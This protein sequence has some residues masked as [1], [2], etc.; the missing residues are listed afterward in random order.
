MQQCFTASRIGVRC[1]F[2]DTT[3]CYFDLFFFHLGL[4][5]V[6][7]GETSPEPD[8]E[9]A[10]NVVFSKSATITYGPWVDKQR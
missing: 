4:V 6:E 8:P 2:T 7:N 5:P 9:W 3:I 10:L 1:E